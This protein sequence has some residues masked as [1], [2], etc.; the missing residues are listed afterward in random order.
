MS[1]CQHAVIEETPTFI[2][3]TIL[4]V[5]KV[6]NLNELIC[7]LEPCHFVEN[8]LVHMYRIKVEFSCQKVRFV[9]H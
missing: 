7:Y 5:L 6:L 8:P 1:I 2:I 4:T 3:T 9:R